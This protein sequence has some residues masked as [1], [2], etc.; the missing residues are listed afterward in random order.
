MRPAARADGPSSTIVWS[1]LDRSTRWARSAINYVGATNEWM[2]DFA[3]NP[4]G[5][6]PFQP[7][8]IETRKYFARAVVMAFAPT[9]TV[10]PSITFADLDPS[11]AFYP[12]ANIAVKLHW[13]KKTAAGTFAPDK[14][15]T[16]TMV[17]RVLT[18]ALGLAPAIKSLNHL[19]TA[20]GVTFEL[21]PNFGA[22]D[23]GDA[24]RDSGTTAPTNRKTWVPRRRSRG[25]RSPTRSTGRRRNPPGTCPS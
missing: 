2:R 10:D 25:R 8:T 9:E 21:P 12:A 17:H 13:M 15:V 4:D 3:P 11:D 18:L 20:D 22:L 7:S 24:P 5:T 19:H 23:P 16:M 1:D 14:A 6:Y